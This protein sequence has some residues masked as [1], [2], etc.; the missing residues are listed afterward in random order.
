MNDASYAWLPYC[1][2]APAPAE[3]LTRWNI[4]PLMIGAML[5]LL[6]VGLVRCPG[7]ARYQLTAAL[8]GGL[9]F[10]SPLCALGSALFAFR[11][12]HH[13]VLLLLLAPLLVFAA[14]ETGSRRFLP[15]PFAT[16]L[17]AAVLWAWHAPPLYAAA[18][19]SDAMF[20]VMQVTL[21]A[22]AA[23]WWAALRRASAL[24]AT[25]S[26]LATMVQMGLLGALLVFAGRPIYAPHLLTTMAWGMGPLED[27]QIAGLIMWVGGSGAYLALAAALL[28][29][30]LAPSAAPHRA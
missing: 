26:V 22:S 16:F 15:L 1:G 11:T 27:Q 5:G 29:R 8:L 10:V 24:S 7:T 23:A 30:A 13:L 3:W 17:Q 25:A 20:W 2:A 18:L 28:Y 19:S 14:G 21:V 12:G 9:L 4:D 6:L